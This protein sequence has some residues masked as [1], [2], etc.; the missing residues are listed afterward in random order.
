MPTTSLK[1]ADDLSDWVES[2]A[3]ARRVSKSAV[4]R[5]A[6]QVYRQTVVEPETSSFFAVAS[7]LAGSVEGPEDLATNP[8]HLA[9]FG[10]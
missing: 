8:V 4:I 5:E 1:L 2:L 10:R 7:D 6:L 3:A 9:G